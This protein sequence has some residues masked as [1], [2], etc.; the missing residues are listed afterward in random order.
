MMNF[1]NPSKVAVLAALACAAFTL[2]ADGEKTL[3][4]NI[5]DLGG[6]SMALQILLNEHPNATDEEK[7]ALTRRFFQGWAIQWSAYYDIDF[8]KDMK[9]TNVHSVD[10]ERVNGVVRNMDEWYD[11]YGIKSGSLYLQPADRVHIW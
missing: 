9:K 3:P 11:A 1:S 5:A 7:A 4:E 10:R 2:Y 8:V 6:C